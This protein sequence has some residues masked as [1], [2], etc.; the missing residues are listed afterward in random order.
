M[1]FNNITALNTFF[2]LKI[3][4]HITLSNSFFSGKTLFHIDGGQVTNLKN[5]TFNEI[6]VSSND[7]YYGLMYLY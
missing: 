2:D 6:N 3:Y 4:K 7:T 1:T 5:L